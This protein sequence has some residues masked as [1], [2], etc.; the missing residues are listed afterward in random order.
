LLWSYDCSNFKQYGGGNFIV[1]DDSGAGVNVNELGT[2][3]KG[4]GIYRP[5]RPNQVAG[6]FDV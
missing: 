1:S 2:G 3:G 6:D 5:G 4:G